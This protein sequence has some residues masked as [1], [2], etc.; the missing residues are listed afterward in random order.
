MVN[1]RASFNAAFN[2]TNLGMASTLSATGNTSAQ[3]C[4]AVR[5]SNAVWLCSQA[6]G[7]GS[8]GMGATS[9]AT[10]PPHGHNL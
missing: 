2:S 4:A 9:P 3:T 8:R 5:S 7:G 10:W 6:H 1:Y